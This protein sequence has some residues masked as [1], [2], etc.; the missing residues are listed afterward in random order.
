MATFGK[1][2]GGFAAWRPRVTG[3]GQGRR[4]EDHRHLALQGKVPLSTDG[5]NLGGRKPRL[6]REASE[7][8][9]CILQVCRRGLSCLISRIMSIG[10]SLLSPLTCLRTQ[11]VPEN[12]PP[13]RCTIIYPNLF[14]SPL[15][16]TFISPFP[17]TPRHFT[18]F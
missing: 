6:H 14:G 13:L 1:L 18:S 11:K 8:H 7:A 17:V 12:F 15:P 3:R 9:G 10:Y 2:E 5:S 16:L 4:N